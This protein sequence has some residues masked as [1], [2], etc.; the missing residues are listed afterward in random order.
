MSDGLT[1]VNRIVQV[2]RQR[3]YDVVWLRAHV[4]RNAVWLADVVVV[5][6]EKDVEFF[7]K[8]LN[9]LPCVLKVLP[10]QSFDRPWT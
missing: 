4:G 9:R 2:M 1:G 5:A 8:R 10:L 7:V 6:T 3:R